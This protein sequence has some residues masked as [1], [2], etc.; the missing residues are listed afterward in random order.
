MKVYM[1]KMLGY[2]ERGLNAEARAAILK[3]RGE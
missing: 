2:V 1:L 3:A